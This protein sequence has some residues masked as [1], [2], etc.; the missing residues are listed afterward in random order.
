MIQSQRLAVD[1]GIPVR[2][3]PLPLLKPS[4][5]YDELQEIISVFERGVFCSVYPT[6]CKVN[7]LETAFAEMIGVK[8]AVAFSSGT[9]AQHASLAAI[10]IEPGDE[11]IVPPLTFISTAYTVLMQGGTVVFADVDEGTFNLDPAMVQEKITSRTRA[12]VPVH[13]FGHP[14]DMDPILALAQEHGLTVIEDCAHAYGTEY[15]GRKAGTMGAMACWSMQE[16]KV[17]TAAGEG[18]MF[19]TDDNALADRARMMRDHGKSQEKHPP[20]PG[21]IPGYEVVVVG[22]NYRMTEIQAAFA[23]AQL[24]QLDAF[25]AQRQAHAMVL[26]D[27]LR[28]VPGL[29]LQAVHPDV[30]LAYAYYPVR[31][32]EANFRA[33]L[34]QISLALTA[35]GIGNYPIAREEMCHMHP[36]FTSRSGHD[37]QQYGPG[38]LP[39]A[40]RIARELL[41]LPL[42][43]NLTHQDLN[44]TIAGVRKVAAAY[45]V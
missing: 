41:I 9:T 43:P 24:R 12:V 6:A 36:V 40:E 4:Y 45:A 34:E 26:D 15:R 2:Q 27:G 3:K 33:G 32:Q 19:T 30:A 39:V 23:L 16:S 29:V 31:F 21:V 18:G 1:G 7:A 8:H 14:V 22:N 25:H 5:G 20:Q 44:D 13:W 11:V 37:G 28:D 10:G 17:I 35:E 42:Y 38:T